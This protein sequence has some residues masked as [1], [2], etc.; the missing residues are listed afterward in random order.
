MPCKT[1]DLKPGTPPLPLIAALSK[2]VRLANDGL[3]KKE[4]F[5]TLLND[6][7]VNALSKYPNIKINKTKYSIPQILNISVMDVMPEVLVHALEKYEIYVSTNTACSSGDI[8]NSII[9]IYND[10]K[11]AKHTIRI[12]LSYVSTTEEVN[13]F[14]E[15]FKSVYGNLSNLR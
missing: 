14:I 11:R 10:I 6:K 15:V 12:S 3:E 8:S 5:V 1:N 13:K 2:A 4:R 7:I 9:A